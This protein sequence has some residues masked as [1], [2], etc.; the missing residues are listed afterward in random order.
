MDQQARSV[1]SNCSVDKCFNDSNGCEGNNNNNLFKV[2]VD[3]LVVARA[4]TC[5][6]REICVCPAEHQYQP[7]SFICSF[8]KVTV[9]APVLSS[10]MVV[11]PRLRSEPVDKQEP[12]SPFRH[13]FF[14]L[15]LLGSKDSENVCTHL[16][17]WNTLKSLL[18]QYA[19]II[20]IINTCIF[21]CRDIQL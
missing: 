18:L 13:H 14:S 15:P 19:I 4:V 1:I 3:L 9:K 8:F 20:I 16:S 17:C 2:N 5:K 12:Q 21:H 11:F 6:C 10:L 7:V